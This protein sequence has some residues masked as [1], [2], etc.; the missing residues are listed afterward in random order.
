M[1]TIDLIDFRRFLRMIAASS[2]S[3]ALITAPPSL[4]RPPE[5]PSETHI[6][7]NGCYPLGYWCGSRTQ[8]EEFNATF[9]LPLSKKDCIKLCDTALRTKYGAY[10]GQGGFGS[11]DAGVGPDAKNPLNEYE[12][13]VPGSVKSCKA[14]DDKRVLCEYTYEKYCPP[15]GRLPAG[16]QVDQ[17]KSKIDEV[18]QLFAVM[19]YLEASAVTA[20]EYLVREL[21]AYDA[22]EHLI[23]IATKGIQEEIEHAQM[24]EALCERYGFNPYPVEVDSFKLRSLAEVAI[25]NCKEG[26]IRETYGALCAIWQAEHAQDQAVREVLYRIESEESHHALM[27]WDIHAWLWPQLNEEEQQ[28]CQQAMFE[29]IAEL[30]ADLHVEPPPALIQ[31]AGLP[32]AKEALR[33]FQQ[34]KQS[35]WA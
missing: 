13:Y 15:A 3:V 14:K 30:E 1:P 29:T 23:Q 7:L 11:T 34:L 9:R 25:D 20:F 17:E 19:N 27:S 18:G 8:S 31:I 16:L 33:M 2:F 6:A 26:C 5:G 21:Q 35:L 4:T 24:T 32:P 10:V 12:G 22:P 28:L